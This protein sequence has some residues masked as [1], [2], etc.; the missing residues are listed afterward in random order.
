MIIL[1]PVN[2]VKGN[3]IIR[4]IESSELDKVLLC[5]NENE[6]NYLSL[7]MKK[8]LTIDDLRQR[9]LE[10]LTNS[11]EYFCGIFYEDMIIG[12]IKGR[13]ENKDLKEL[14]IMSYLI[15]RK[16]RGKGIGADIIKYFE[17][18]FSYYYS[19]DKYC[20]LVIED[21]ISD[22]NFWTNNKYKLTRITTG[23]EID[24][25]SMKIFEKGVR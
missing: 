7:G 11:L 9:Y 15:I 16:F 8:Q 5:I 6:E 20:V 18:Y 2:I 24:D 25:I 22:H 4:N 17:D 21:D 13:I 19:V 14:W 12:I 23:T 1:I 3:Y 10:T